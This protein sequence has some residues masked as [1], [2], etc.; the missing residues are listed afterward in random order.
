MGPAPTTLDNML[1]ATISPLFTIPSLADDGTNWITYK[2]RLLNAIGARGLMRYIDGRT[3]QPLPF[4][5]DPKGKELV[6]EDG[7]PATEAEQ[8]AREDKID[9]WYQKDA[10]VKQ[11]IFS[12]I[13]NRLLLRVQKLPNALEIWEE[14]RHIHEG[15]TELVQV[16]L[17][18]R[19]QDT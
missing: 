5:L 13:T 18:Q 2:E 15:K 14:I 1:P 8:E 10:Y 12:T 7:K 9:E 4:K 17:R 3:K 19:L 6:K 11:H 16:D